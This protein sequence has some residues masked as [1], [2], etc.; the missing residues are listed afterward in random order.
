[1]LGEVR[2]LGALRGHR[3][4]PPADVQALVRA[5]SGVVRLAQELGDRLVSLEA[6][7]IVVRERDQGAL[8]V[9]LRVALTKERLPSE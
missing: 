8:A 5:I 4:R 3:G 2:A 1:M 7:P 6:N 9:D